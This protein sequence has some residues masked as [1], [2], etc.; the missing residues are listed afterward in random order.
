M[1]VKLTGTERKVIS[2]LN[3][4]KFEVNTKFPDKTFEIKD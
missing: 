4:E 3:I 2:K 1:Q